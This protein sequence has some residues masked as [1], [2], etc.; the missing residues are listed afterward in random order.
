MYNPTVDQIFDAV[1]KDFPVAY[2][3]SQ[4]EGYPVTNILCNSETGDL[5]IEMATTGYESDDIEV[6]LDGKTLI[7]RG[8]DKKTKDSE[9]YIYIH[10]KIKSKRD[11]EKRFSL[12]RELKTESIKVKNK[13]GLLTIDVPF[14]TDKTSE[15]KLIIE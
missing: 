6:S 4:G 5:R 15:K 14:D 10:Q 1:F 9:G 12:P 8:S 2:A 7:I 13:N 11:F 3:R